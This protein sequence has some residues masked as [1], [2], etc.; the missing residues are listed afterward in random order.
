MNKFVPAE[1]WWE[2]KGHKIHL[3]SFCNPEA[4]VKVIM[5]YC[6]VS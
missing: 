6:S 5:L 2:W 1:E 3:D 4:K